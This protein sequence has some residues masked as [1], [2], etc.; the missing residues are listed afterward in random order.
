MSASI[1]MEYRTIQ[2]KGRK[3]DYCIYIKPDYDSQPGMAATIDA[4][5][6]HLPLLSI[7]AID[8]LDLFARPVAIP[9]ETKRP[10]EGLD[11]AKLQAAMWLSAQYAILH[12]FLDDGDQVPLEPGERKP[13]LQDF[14]YLPGIIVQGHIWTLLAATYNGDGIVSSSFLSFSSLSLV[15]YPLLTFEDRLVWNRHWIDP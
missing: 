14:G 12:R 11:T 10:G 1:I 6:K 15:R 3:V 2:P 8:Q 5:R 7:N 13:Q 9:I 4:Y